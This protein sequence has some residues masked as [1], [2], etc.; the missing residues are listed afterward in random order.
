MRLPVVEFRLGQARIRQ[1]AHV[2]KKEI[3][4]RGMI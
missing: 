4:S 1:I 3:I 2:Q